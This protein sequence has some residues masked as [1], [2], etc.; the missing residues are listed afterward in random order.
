MATLRSTAIS[1]LRLTGTT[2]IA[3]ATRHHA[4]DAH[5]PVELLLTCKNPTLPGPWRALPT[6]RAT[7][8]AQTQPPACRTGH[9]A[10]PRTRHTSDHFVAWRSVKRTPRFPLTC[11]KARMG[12]RRHTAASR[13]RPGWMLLATA[14][15]AGLLAGCGPGSLGPS[16]AGSATSGGAANV[17]DDAE[18][19]PS[20]SVAISRVLPFTQFGD[21][22]NAIVNDSTGHSDQDKSKF[23][24]IEQAIAEC[25]K[26]D[27]FEYEPRTYAKPEEVKFAW[28]TNTLHLPVISA[29]RAEVQRFGYGKDDVDKAEASRKSLETL[30][31]NTAYL[32]GLSS[33]AQT[34]YVYALT[35]QHGPD[36]TN[37]D[38]TDGCAGRAQTAF[39][40]TAKP[41]ESAGVEYAP[42]IRAMRGVIDNDLYRDPGTITLNNE[43]SGCMLDASHDVAPP[44]EYSQ[45]LTPGPLQAY[46]LAVITPP[47]GK[48]TWP[49]RDEPAAKI[50]LEQRYLVGSAAEHAI[51]LADY[52]CR[53]STNYV[54]R[55]TDI[56][57]SLED[58]FVEQHQQ[59]LTNMA[60]SAATR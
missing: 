17:A 53:T 42:L 56:L 27:G 12:H 50:P 43:W 7:M 44:A 14:G 6:P 41:D 34:E 49:A 21:A 32:E 18:V 54:Q 28:L 59:E 38:P 15:I 37:P 35:G 20:L 33:Q 55:S 10:Q 1:V 22:V 5:R 24:S 47:A 40:G 13:V 45:Q 36:D 52:D 29:E 16:A 25:M 9:A 3:R 11:Y 4:R 46:Q 39:S 58:G 31:S 26:A 51:A 48:A 60:T 30:D 2:S 19:S 57:V 8:A 23:D